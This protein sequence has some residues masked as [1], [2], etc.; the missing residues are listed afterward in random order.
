MTSSIVITQ[1]LVIWHFNGHNHWSSNTTSG[2]DVPHFPSDIIHENWF[3]SV[4]QPSLWGQMVQFASCPLFA[5]CS[6][7]PLRSVQGFTAPHWDSGHLPINRTV[8][9][10]AKVSCFIRLLS[11]HL[12]ASC[13]SQSLIAFTLAVHE[14]KVYLI[15]GLGINGP[16]GPLT[17][18]FMFTPTFASALF[19]FGFGW[20]V[21]T[22]ESPLQLLCVKLQKYQNRNW[23][24]PNQ[25]VIHPKWQII[26]IYFV[27]YI[28]YHL[29]WSYKNSHSRVLSVTQCSVRWKSLK[30]WK[31]LVLF[32]FLCRAKPQHLPGKTNS[33]YL[34]FEHKK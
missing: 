16:P 18:K 15:I 25:S 32:R 2:I 6:L 28:F 1:Q 21:V 19:S 20:Y 4:L 33:I 13:F 12:L 9:H 29:A 24:G 5:L 30:M 7:I 23:R 26:L 10:S 27:L 22:P 11:T 31:E 14:F 17:D 34:Y 3:S 8:A